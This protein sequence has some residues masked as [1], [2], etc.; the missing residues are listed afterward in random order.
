MWSFEVALTLGNRSK[1]NRANETNAFWASKTLFESLKHRQQRWLV[2]QGKE[3]T[4]RQ[5]WSHSRSKPFA[6]ISRFLSVWCWKL[7]SWMNIPKRRVNHFNSIQNS[8]I[9]FHSFIL[10]FHCLTWS[11]RWNAAR[12]PLRGIRVSWQANQQRQKTHF[13]IEKEDCK[14]NL[15]R[16]RPN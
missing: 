13:E 16:T 15:N 2:R 11:L 10:C 1:L 12:K 7:Y 9:N 5:T 8:F 14:T 6:S 4:S 3:R